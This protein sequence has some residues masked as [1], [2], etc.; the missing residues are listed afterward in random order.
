MRG[1]GDSPGR[2]ARP[3]VAATRQV[4]ELAAIPLSPAASPGVA[5]ALL[6]DLERAPAAQ[7]GP[8]RPD[9]RDAKTSR[10]R[11]DRA[12]ADMQQRMK[13]GGVKELVI[14]VGILLTVV[15]GAFGTYWVRSQGVEAAAGTSTV[16]GKPAGETTRPRAMVPAPPAGV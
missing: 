3:A 10:P 7:G 9:H 11:K 2:A 4:A 15:A 8:R 14:L 12:M 6:W 1:C 16:T 13:S 5:R